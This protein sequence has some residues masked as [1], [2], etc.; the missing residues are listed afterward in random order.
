MPG[1][2]PGHSTLWVLVSLFDRTCRVNRTSE[3]RVICKRQM[4][5]III[6]NHSKYWFDHRKHI[7]DNYFLNV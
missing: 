7:Y 4:K 6:H 5:N 2:I 1:I 3:I